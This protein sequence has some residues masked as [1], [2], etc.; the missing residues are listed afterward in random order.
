MDIV[1]YSTLPITEQTRVLRERT[2]F[3]KDGERFRQAEA[4]GSSSVFIW[5][6]HGARSL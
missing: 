3:V 2:R 4:E 5:R 1:K 6:R